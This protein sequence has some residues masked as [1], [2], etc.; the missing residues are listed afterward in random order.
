MS[1]GSLTTGSHSSHFAEIGLLFSIQ[2]VV[3]VMAAV[4]VC[5]SFRALKVE[6]VAQLELLNSLDFFS[7][8][9]WVELINPLAEPVSI[10]AGH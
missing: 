7:W 4:E 9:R 3:M 8:D 10:N 6:D 5:T 2:S 1:L